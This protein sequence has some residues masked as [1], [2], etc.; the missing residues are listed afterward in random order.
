MSL[1]GAISVEKIASGTE[2]QRPQ[3]VFQLPEVKNV[4]GDVLPPLGLCYIH[5]VCVFLCNLSCAFVQDALMCFLC[6][7]A[8]SSTFG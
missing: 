7:K 5:V 8:I 3:Q 1:R 4:F 6:K 2:L